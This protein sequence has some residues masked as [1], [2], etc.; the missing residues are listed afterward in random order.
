VE[1][2]ALKGVQ[3]AHTAF[4]AHIKQV[5]QKIFRETQQQLDQLKDVIQSL[6]PSLCPFPRPPSRRSCVLIQSQLLG[7]FVWVMAID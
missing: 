4:D 5:G 7:W 6:C 3:T 2:L 1:A